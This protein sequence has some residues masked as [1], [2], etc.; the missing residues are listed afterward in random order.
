MHS[1]LSD[2]RPESVAYVHV[3]AS[4]SPNLHRFG[5]ELVLVPA[6]AQA[7][8]LASQATQVLSGDPTDK[9]HWLGRG[10]Q[11]LAP[12][13]KESEYTICNLKIYYYYNTHTYLYIELFFTSM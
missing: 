3:N 12:H 10:I 6:M 2:H 11:R 8:I 5:Q 1:G 13:Q 7:T 4:T 9:H